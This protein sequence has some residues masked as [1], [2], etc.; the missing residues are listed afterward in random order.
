MRAAILA[1]AL[2]AAGCFNVDEQPCSFACGPNGACPDDYMCLSDRYCHLHGQP[3]A[4]GYSDAAM[5]PDA[6]VDQSMTM[7]LTTTDAPMSVDGGADLAMPDLAMP[8]LAMPDLTP[9][10]DLLPLPDS[11]SPPDASP[12]SLSTTVLGIG[13]LTSTPSGINCD[14]TGTG[15]CSANFADNASITLSTTGSFKAWGAGPCQAMGATT[16]CTFNLTSSQSQTAAFYAAGNFPATA[17]ATVADNAVL[18]PGS[19]TLEAYVSLTSTTEPSSGYVA[20]IQKGDP[21]NTA[22]GYGLYYDWDTLNF[23]ATAVAGS[24]HC[25]GAATPAGAH[26]LAMEYDA[27]TGNIS[28]YVDG[29]SACTFSITAGALASTTSPL[30]FGTPSSATRTFAGII[31][32]VRIS[33]AA[34]YSGASYTTARH[35]TVQ[36]STVGLWHLDSG[37]G[38]TLRDSSG[39]GFDAT[40]GGTGFTWVAEP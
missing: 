6:N 3:G 14:V 40:V 12:L 17:N 5:A 1:C 19:V 7:D 15:T 11:S 36:A 27:S 29:S 16:P 28:L 2:L 26:Y 35:Q 24:G 22:N 34:L 32:E 8:D 31:D 4:C 33:N 10:A 20:A 21:I 18:N 23:Y 38:T 37:Q 39:N 9:P 25:S 13:T 30:V